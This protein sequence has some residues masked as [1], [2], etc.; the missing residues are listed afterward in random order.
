MTETFRRLP[1]PQHQ[2]LLTAARRPDHLIPGIEDGHVPRSERVNKRTLVSLYRAG[3]GCDR[4]SAYYDRTWEYDADSGASLWLTPKGRAY[5]RQSGVE[6]RRRQVVVIQC[7]DKKAE[8]SWEKYHYRGVVPAGQLYVGPYHR[9]LRLAASALTNPLLTWIMSARHGLVELKRPLGPY[10]VRLGDSKSV[11]AEQMRRHG[12]SLDLADA[13]V[14]FLG[15][16]KYAELFREVVPH[17]VT[18]LAGDL[19]A[20]RSQCAAVRRSPDL[21]R[22]WWRAAAELS[23]SLG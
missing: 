7:G 18:P 13:D 2:A 21:V 15:S 1:E 14:I 10:D 8:P 5:V 4:P 9:S 12:A 3:F 22:E 16:R 17:A 23:R 11:T 19:L 20:Q 6:C